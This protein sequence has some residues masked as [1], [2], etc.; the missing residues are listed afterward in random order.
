MFPMPTG[1]EAKMSDKRADEWLALIRELLRI[2][3]ARK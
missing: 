2:L 1:F 3:A